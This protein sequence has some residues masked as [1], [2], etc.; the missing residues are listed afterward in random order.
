VA[1]TSAADSPSAP[2]L[3]SGGDDGRVAVWDWRAGCGVIGVL[4]GAL[5]HH[6][7]TCA[8]AHCAWAAEVG[9]AAADRVPLLGE[10]DNGRKVQAL[11]AGRGGVLAVA[12]TGRRVGIHR[13]GEC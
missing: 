2:W 8:C 5:H 12:D 4:A 7:P 3:A 13:L 10:A 9:E 1:F 11:A 6:A